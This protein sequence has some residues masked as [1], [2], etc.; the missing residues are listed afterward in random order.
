MSDRLIDPATEP[1]AFL[2][3]APKLIAGF[4]ALFEDTITVDEQVQQVV[5]ADL[6]GI[7]FVVLF[8]RG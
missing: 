5:D 7:P 8:K 4:G 3:F 1:S 2:R 6:T